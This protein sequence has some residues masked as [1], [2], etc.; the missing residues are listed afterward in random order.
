MISATSIF[1]PTYFQVPNAFAMS[2]PVVALLVRPH[3]A[4]TSRRPKRARYCTRN[5]L[6]ALPCTSKTSTQTTL[7]MSIFPPGYHAGTP[8]M[9]ASTLHL[10]SILVIKTPSRRNRGCRSP[11]P[12]LIGPNTKTTCSSADELALRAHGY[13]DGFNDQRRQAAQASSIS[14][15]LGIG[16]GA[17]IL[18]SGVL[19]QITHWHNE[20]EV[21]RT[22]FGNI[23]GL[24]KLRFTP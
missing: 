10:L 11:S 5:S 22:V 9:T 14:L 2:L 23:L 1:L 13:A 17:F 16:M 8:S 15:G 3:C 7:L 6:R 12:L 18:L 21:H 24:S 20:N 4:T 19:P